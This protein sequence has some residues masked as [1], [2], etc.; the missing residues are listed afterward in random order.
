M[1]PI[2]FATLLACAVLSACTS[3]P[4]SDAPEATASKAPASTTASPAAGAS[5]SPSPSPAESSPA[6]AAAPPSPPATFRPGVVVYFD[7]VEQSYNAEAKATSYVHPNDGQH[8]LKIETTLPGAGYEGLTLTL[9]RDGATLAP[10]FTAGQVDRTS[11]LVRHSIT[12]QQYVGPGA[13]SLT[14]TSTT[15]RLTGVAAG[16]VKPIA[17]APKTQ[18]FVR[19]EF[20]VE[21]PAVTPAS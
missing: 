3:P 2:G 10:G 14:L 20:D 8:T 1:R 13:E 6:A 16:Q 11:I 7:G 12:P 17:G 9:I 19:V 5:P 15:G 21:M 4:T 18:P